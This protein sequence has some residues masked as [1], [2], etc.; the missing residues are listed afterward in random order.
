M[1]YKVFISYSS[2]DRPWAE[3]LWKDLKGSMSVFWDQDELRVGQ[4]WDPQLRKAITDCEHMV[5]LWSE[6][7]KQSDWVQNERTTFS[8]AAEESGGAKRLIQVRLEGDSP[9]LSAYQAIDDIR[10]GKTFYKP[11]SPPPPDATPAA[12]P[13]HDPF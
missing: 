11:K 13:P 10:A 9:V 2:E 8:Q 7:A 6:A 1:P 5:I 3:K 4:K 12:D